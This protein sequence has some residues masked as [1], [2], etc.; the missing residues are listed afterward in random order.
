MTMSLN[1]SKTKRQFS[2]TKRAMNNC[3]HRLKL[4][5]APTKTRM[6]A[7]KSGFHFLGIDFAVTQIQQNAEK[8]TRVQVQLHP[9]AYYRAIDK[10]KLKQ[11]EAKALG[12]AASERAK[13]S[14]S[15]GELVEQATP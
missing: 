13:L 14:L 6:G 15:M 1:F 7:L 10:V 4:T 12:W 5:Y 9:R 8:I 11:E 3:L 2:R